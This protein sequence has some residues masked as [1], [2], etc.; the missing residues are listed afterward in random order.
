MGE[1]HLHDW[2]NRGEITSGDLP[3]GVTRDTIREDI[4]TTRHLGHRGE[5]SGVENMI[6]ETF[7]PHIFSGKTKSLSPIVGSLSTILFKKSGLGLLNP[8]TSEK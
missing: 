6:W 5:F 3:H 7:L 8:M 1:E 2:Q 4:S